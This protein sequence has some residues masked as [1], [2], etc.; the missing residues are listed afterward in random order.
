MADFI[1]IGIDDNGEQQFSREI[2]NIVASH[3][4]FSGGK[5]HRELVQA[6]LPQDHEWIDITVP[7]DRVF[8]A[9]EHHDR[10]VVFTSGDPLFFGFA[11]TIRKRLPQA[12][13]KLYPY[14]NS[15]QMLAHRLLLPYHDMYTVSLTGRPWHEFDRAL[16]EGRGKIGLLT[17]REKTPLTISAR[18]AEYGYTN[19]R[20]TVGESLGNTQERIRHF[21]YFNGQ[22]RLEHSGE[23]M[24]TCEFQ[25]PNCILLRQTVRR[26]RP[27]GI[28]ETQFHLL[29]GRTKMI[30]KMPVRLLALSLL[31]LRSCE[32][33]WDIGFCTGSVSIE[34]KL[35]FPHLH[36]TAFEQREEGRTLIQTNSI[37]FGTPGIEWRIG[38]FTMLDLSD[39]PDPDAAFIGGHGGK[40]EEIL[41]ILR[42]KIRPG[43]NIVFNSVSP[44]SREAFTRLAGLQGF[45]I[46]E[47]HRIA[48]DDNNPIEIIKAIKSN[49]HD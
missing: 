25:F 39:L 11:N 7:L 6:R 1:V 36:I 48:I 23:E 44:A 19:Y 3:R 14:F 12:E 9:Y 33:F 10:I 8:E 37:R 2:E 38:D 24:A 42:R 41:R 5:R 22:F 30:T 45:T 43:G 49:L 31:E 34:A 47:R 15:L 46:A 4:I 13:I 26:E 20:I 16:I 18:M 35:Q 29:N 40:L 27:F 32:Y 21:E 28:P 17:D